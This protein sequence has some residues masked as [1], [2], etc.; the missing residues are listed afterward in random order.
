MLIFVYN[1]PGVV[2]N[3]LEGCSE[4]VAGQLEL[5]VWTLE[6]L[7]MVPGESFMHAIVMFQVSLYQTFL[8]TSSYSIHIYYL[9]IKMEQEQNSIYKG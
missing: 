5:I 4:A 2:T 9:Q 8:P 1:C 6:I 7:G 3:C